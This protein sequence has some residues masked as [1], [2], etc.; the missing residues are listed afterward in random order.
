[1]YL[2]DVVIF[3]KFVLNFFFNFQHFFCENKDEINIIF[4]CN[5]L[6]LLLVP[7]TQTS[8]LTLVYTAPFVFFF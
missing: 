3:C 4:F 6:L 8:D 5:K 2:E 7:I 1:M